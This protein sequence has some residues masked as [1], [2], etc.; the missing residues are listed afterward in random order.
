M[1][2]VEGAL[3]R[4]DV[5]L[6]LCNVSAKS[7]AH[8]FIHMSH[9]RVGPPTQ[10]IFNGRHKASAYSYYQRIAISIHLSDVADSDDP[11][12]DN[13]RIPGPYYSSDQDILDCGCCGVF[14]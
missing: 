5:I 11:L 9:G 6:V 1:S 13:A 7:V 10:I 12:R 14:V 3:V 8:F 2:F 4:L